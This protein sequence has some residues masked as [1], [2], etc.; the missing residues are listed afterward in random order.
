MNPRVRIVSAIFLIILA[1]LTIWAWRAN[2]GKAEADSQFAVSSASAVIISLDLK[3]GKFPVRCYEPQGAPKAILV[4]GSGDGGWKSWEEKAARGLASAGF[5]V[6]G[7]DCRAYAAKPYD[8]SGLGADV[9]Q[10][11]KEG[12][13]RAARD[14]ITGEKVPIPLFYGGYSTGAE[15]AVGAAASNLQHRESSVGGAKEEISQY[16]PS[17]LLLVAPGERGRY[18]ITLA[19]LLGRTPRGPT[20]FALKELAPRLGTIPVAQIHGSLDPLDS[21]EWLQ[22]LKGPHRLNTLSGFGHFFGDAGTDLR[23]TLVEDAEWLV[24][25]SSS[26]H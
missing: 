24:R 10:M 15:Q 21:T 13:K 8:A 17:G 14:G 5:K 1:T 11:A 7:W 19:D 12:L 16:C 22:F 18:G 2:A 4:F 20:S 6:I 26:S 9:A 3:R 23:K 25:Q